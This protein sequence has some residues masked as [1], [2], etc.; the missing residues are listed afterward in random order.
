[1]PCT[2]NGIDSAPSRANICKLELGESGRFTLATESLA[3]GPP[4][5]KGVSPDMDRIG[6]LSHNR[7][8]VLFIDLAGCS[9][10]EVAETLRKVPAY[11]TAQPR[12]SVLALIDFTKASFDDEAVRVMQE[13]AV[14]DKPF[15][16]RAAWIAASDL[17]DS[18]HQMVSEFALREFPIFGSRSAALDWLTAEDS[19]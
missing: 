13:I 6:L 14:F 12:R 3:W 5:E 7:Q 9:P 2:S 19:A 16:K 15:I 4:L 8:S 11:V 10:A 17:P 1:M 18:F